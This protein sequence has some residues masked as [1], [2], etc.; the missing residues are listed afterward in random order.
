MKFT[1]FFLGTAGDM[2]SKR[3]F[4]FILIVLFCV[5]FF[6]NLFFGKMLKD[7]LEENLFYLIIVMF[8]GVAGEPLTKRKKEEAKPDEPKP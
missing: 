4:L 8:V 2:S 1:Q 6:A 5:Y 3:L 7:S